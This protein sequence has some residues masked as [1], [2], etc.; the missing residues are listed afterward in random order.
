MKPRHVVLASLLAVAACG[1]S[2]VTSRSGDSVGVAGA[3]F[4]SPAMALPK[5]SRVEAPAPFASAVAK[6][7]PASAD[8]SAAQSARADQGPPSFA[9]PGSM[10][11]RTGRASVQVDSLERGI[12]RVRELAHGTSAIIGNTTVQSGREQLRTATL[13]LRVPADHFDDLVAGLRGFGTVE[14]VDVS[15]AD[16]GEEYVDV[17]ARV[18]TAQQLE[19]RLIDLLAARTGKLADVL[20]VENELARVRSEIERYE[21][22]LRYLRER[23]AVS[24]LAITLH[25]PTPVIADH[26][27]VNPIAEATRQAWRNFVSVLA[28][29]IASLGVLIPLAVIAIAG[30]V[31]GRRWIGRRVTVPATID[32]LPLA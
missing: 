2:T 18:A 32:G 21:G 14:A 6:R 22:R 4:A 1:N 3:A 23:S 28:T 9:I 27:G 25:E 24:T 20:Q 15:V 7:T 31:L 16:V 11:V 30:I 29:I 19:R 8:A 5:D 13:E 26:P 10:L 12:S 17:A